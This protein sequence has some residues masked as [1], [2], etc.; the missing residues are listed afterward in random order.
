MRQTVVLASAIT[1][2]I[3]LSFSLVV[4]IQSLQNASADPEFFVGVEFAYSS[5]LTDLKG[6]VD[7]VKNYT[8]LFV[9]G[10]LDITANETVLNQ[11]CDYVVGSGV[12][13]D[14]AVLRKAP[15]T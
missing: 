11:A 15:S 9:I 13:P 8:N 10:S 4:T 6:L 1:L 2:I 5:N 12:A 14:C 3:I 7:Q